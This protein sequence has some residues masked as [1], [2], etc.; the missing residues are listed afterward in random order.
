MNSERVAQRG[1]VAATKNFSV[2]SV[3]LKPQPSAAEPQFKIPDSEFRKPE[4]VVVSF[5]RFSRA[6]SH[7]IPAKAGIQYE[8]A[9]I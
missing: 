6:R 2:S 9:Q 7:V 1:P 3:P 8:G 5:A 4:R